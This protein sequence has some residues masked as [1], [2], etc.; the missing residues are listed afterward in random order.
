MF[1]PDRLDAIVDLLT[2]EEQTDL[3]RAID[4]WQKSRDI[5]DA[6]DP[7]RRALLRQ[8][9]RELRRDNAE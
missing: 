1:D 6:L 3:V 7:L 9:K 2:R 4:D 5:P 8:A